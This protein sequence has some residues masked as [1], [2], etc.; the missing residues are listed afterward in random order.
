[1]AG[2]RAARRRRERQERIS[3]KRS[4]VPLEVTTRA[5]WN[6]H[7]LVW[8]TEWVCDIRGNP[9]RRRMSRADAVDAVIADLNA[10]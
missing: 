4:R 7:R 6:A 9:I 3:I 8:L 2:N 5:T 10:A 1:M